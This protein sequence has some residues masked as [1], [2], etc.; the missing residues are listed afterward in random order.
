[1]F[2]RKR[3]MPSSFPYANG[4]ISTNYQLIANNYMARA[5]PH[6]QNPSFRQAP[7]HPYWNG[8]TGN[9]AGL[10]SPFYSQANG[11]MPMEQTWKGGSGGYGQKPNVSQLLFENP[12][13]PQTENLYGGYY[14]QNTSFQSMNP[15]P[16][17]AYLPK[18][19]NGFHS[20]IN[21]FKNQ[22]GNMDVNKMID[23]AGQM[24]NAVTQVSTMVKG[25]GGIFKA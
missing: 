13:Q 23:T 10:T 24:M 6:Q 11:F 7:Y 21:S 15:Y 20:V 16:H 18:K 25:L 17:Q 12:L 4:P 19:T 5:M 8:M 9:A 22:D 1:M 2:G 14:P 3:K